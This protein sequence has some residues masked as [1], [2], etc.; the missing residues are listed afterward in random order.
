MPKLW[1]I[2]GAVGAAVVLILTFLANL[3]TFTNEYPTA[4]P[5]WARLLAPYGEAISA[6]TPGLLFYGFLIAALLAVLY[7]QIAGRRH[8]E[9]LPIAPVARAPESAPAPAVVQEPPVPMADIEWLRRGYAPWQECIHDA[10]ALLERLREARDL[11][12][13][14]GEKNAIIATLLRRLIEESSTEKNA[15]DN[16]L[17]H[18]RNFS[19]AEYRELRDAM[20]TLI[21]H[22]YPPLT[23]WIMEAGTSLLGKDRLLRGADY[24]ELYAAHQKALGD[25]REARMTETFRHIAENVKHLEE[26]LPPPL[27]RNPR[28]SLEQSP[29]ELGLMAR[30]EGRD[31]VVGRYWMGRLNII[32]VIPP[33]NPARDGLR[34]MFVC[35]RPGDDRA[36]GLFY[37][38]PEEARLYLANRI[39][40]RMEIT[41]AGKIADAMSEGVEPRAVLSPAE[42]VNPEDLVFPQQEGS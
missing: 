33:G 8:E 18:G 12:I 14:D 27:E 40:P 29:K 2:L 19:K 28:E 6:G 16:A 15:L 41:I 9:S 34:L 3:A 21:I 39:V 22:S 20:Q 10:I 23:Y 31:V 4:A 13:G 38:Y 5:R 7:A 30:W 26:R 32:N 11:W 35:A 17:G 25:A 42:F 36:S 37:V 24:A 1:K